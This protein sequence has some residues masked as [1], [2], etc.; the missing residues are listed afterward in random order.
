MSRIL[1]FLKKENN[2]NVWGGI[3]VKLTTSRIPFLVFFYPK[4]QLSWKIVTLYVMSLV[5]STADIL[6]IVPFSGKSWIIG[7][8]LW[9]LLEN[10]I[11]R[12]HQTKLESCHR[13]HSLGKY[14][15]HRQYQSF[16]RSM[17]FH[18][19]LYVTIIW[20]K[21]GYW[22]YSRQITTKYNTFG[23]SNHF[24]K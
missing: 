12:E 9:I 1:L 16:A 6:Y 8:S 4:D 15:L 17:A 24:K 21:V 19:S 20:N 3:T 2:W 5:D 23:A 18:L 22:C 11:L 13:V 10:I 14:P 7:F